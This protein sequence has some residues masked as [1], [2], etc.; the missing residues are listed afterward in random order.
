[1]KQTESN[2]MERKIFICQCQSLEHQVGFWYDE[3]DDYLYC[4]P[5]LKTHR[6]FFKRLWVALKY[7]FGFRSRYG[8]WDSTIFEKEDMKK[9]R[10]YLNK[11]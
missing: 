1:M 10:D 8:H 11:I 9:L 2:L 5:H 4:E 3:E 6:N 7:V